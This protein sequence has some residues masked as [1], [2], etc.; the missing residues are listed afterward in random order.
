MTSYFTTG[1][2]EN[3][4]QNNFVK[5]KTQTTEEYK[6]SIYKPNLNKGTKPKI[7]KAPGTAARKENQVQAK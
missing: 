2:G 3:R 5:K 1:A 7:P 6:H 4:K